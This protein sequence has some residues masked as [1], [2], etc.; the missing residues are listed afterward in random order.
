MAKLRKRPKGHSESP[1][2]SKSTLRMP[3]STGPPVLPV[4]NEQ[5]AYTAQQLHHATNHDRQRSD[6]KVRDVS[7][8]RERVDVPRSDWTNASP[9]TSALAKT[10]QAGVTKAQRRPSPLRISQEVSA[11]SEAVVTGPSKPEPEY[12]RERCGPSCQK[13]GRPRKPFSPDVSNDEITRAS[14]TNW[15]LPGPGNEMFPSTSEEATEKAALPEPQSEPEALPSNKQRSRRRKYFS[16]PTKS[17]PS[18]KGPTELA[19]IKGKAVEPPMYQEPNK[20]KARPVSAPSPTKTAFKGP[21]DVGTPT[22]QPK[23]VARVH[24]ARDDHLGRF[25]TEIRPASGTTLS[26]H[27]QASASLTVGPDLEIPGQRDEQTSQSL[28]AQPQEVPQLHPQALR[29]A[30]PNL[31]PNSAVLYEWPLITTLVNQPNA[32]PSTRR[33]PL[34]NVQSRS[35]LSISKRPSRRSSRPYHNPHMHA[36]IPGRTS[37]RHKALLQQSRKVSYIADHASNSSRDSISISILGM[38]QGFPGGE[39][40]ATA[41]AQG[42]TKTL[43]ERP[44]LPRLQTYPPDVSTERM[45][46]NKDEPD[47]E[48]NGNL[49]SP[50]DYGSDEED[51]DDD[52]DDQPM[53][54]T[55]PQSDFS[56][57]SYSI[58]DDKK[59][60]LRPASTVTQTSFSISDDRHLPLKKLPTLNSSPLHHPPLL[61]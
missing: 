37:S 25:A 46:L 42:D 49:Y 5:P 61:L 30:Q 54:V 51:D 53:P 55:P 28:I 44:S 27:H 6:S 31:R 14:P 13:C 9:P 21:I 12:R 11:V 39:L 32:D 52:D 22:P 26:P 23:A 10:E 48:I 40:A 57:A 20:E 15:P 8:G 36:P 4:I 50:S 38:F 34:T 59:L 58:G 18:F 29:A 7:Q 19:S 1:R 35:S 60:N 16:L 24:F 43:S 3:D 41:K 2:S 33:P 17:K 47:S 45:S 56:L